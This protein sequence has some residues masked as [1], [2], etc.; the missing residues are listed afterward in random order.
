MTSAEWPDLGTIG[1]AHKISSFKSLNSGRPRWWAGASYTGT[2]WQ[3]AAGAQVSY[4]GDG[5]NDRFRSVKNL[6]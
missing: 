6:P 1:W 3:W 5:A 2:Y 4:V